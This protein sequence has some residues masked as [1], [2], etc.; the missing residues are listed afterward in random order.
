MAKKGARQDEA[1]TEMP[2]PII[3]EVTERVPPLFGGRGVVGQTCRAGFFGLKGRPA[4]RSM[5]AQTR[6]VAARRGTRTRNY[7]LRADS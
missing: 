6:R 3:L 7:S 2:S 5:H 1:A 4:G